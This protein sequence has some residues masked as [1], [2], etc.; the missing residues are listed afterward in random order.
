MTASPSDRKHADCLGEVADM[1][2]DHKK[3]SRNAFLW[4]L[5]LLGLGVPGLIML[6]ARLAMSIAWIPDQWAFLELPRNAIEPGIDALARH[7]WEQLDDIVD[8]FQ[9]M[10]I[11]DRPW[12]IRDFALL[13]S[14]SELD[15]VG[16]GPAREALPGVSDPLNLA[17][18]YPALEPFVRGKIL[19]AEGDLE[20]ARQSYEDGLDAVRSPRCGNCGFPTAAKG[21][22]LDRAM[23]Y[24]LITL[25]VTSGDQVHLRHASLQLDELL[26]SKRKWTKC[27]GEHELLRNAPSDLD[28]WIRGETACLR[29]YVDTN[30]VLRTISE[31][32]GPTEAGKER[33]ESI[34]D[35]LERIVDDDAFLPIVRLRVR[36]LWANISLALCDTSI[37]DIR[38]FVF[39]DRLD[40]STG[41]SSY[42]GVWPDVDRAMLRMKVHLKKSE[43][44]AIREEADALESLLRDAGLNRSPQYVHLLD[45]WRTRADYSLCASRGCQTPNKACTSE[46]AERILTPGSA[47]P[48][49]AEQDSDRRIRLEHAVE[50]YLRIPDRA[51]CEN[52]HSAVSEMIAGI[53]EAA[54]SGDGTSGGAHRN[55]AEINGI[56]ACLRVV[57]SGDLTSE[58]P[59]MSGERDD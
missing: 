53:E 50:V 36:F 27:F 34:R 47:F 12:A 29:A 30:Q 48:Y 38:E 41:G 1:C 39:T 31:G 40:P 33:L 9:G 28:D 35:S 8:S 59:A 15:G 57:C 54:S 21:W 14:A 24:D 23:R 58:E 37:E 20:G 49:S 22:I 25:L 56:Q 17:T 51:G 11:V 42:G 16:V 55:N 44:R 5:G 32:A 19:W 2:S 46:L 6:L 26:E 7:N 10:Q 43:F 45:Y 18:E 13:A 3:P 4:L 52:A